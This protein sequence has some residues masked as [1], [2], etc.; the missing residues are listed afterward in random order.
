MGLEDVMDEIL[1]WDNLCGIVCM[2]VTVGSMKEARALVIVP[3]CHPDEPSSQY[4]DTYKSPTY[5]FCREEL[6][7][8]S[9]TTTKIRHVR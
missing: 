2:N 5:I 6:Q 4:C 3:E 7:V 1:V 9:I 8:R